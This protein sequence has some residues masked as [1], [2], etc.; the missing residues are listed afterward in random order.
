MSIAFPLRHRTARQSPALATI[1]SLEYGSMIRMLAKKKNHF[2]EILKNYQRE[3]Q[4]KRHLE[5]SI[6]SK[7]TRV[8]HL[9]DDVGRLVLSHLNH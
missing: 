5:V 3:A 9:K 2:Q 8:M 1:N 4:K 7:S 6:F